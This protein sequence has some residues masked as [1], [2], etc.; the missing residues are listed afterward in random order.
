MKISE[1]E[2][3]I[4]YAFNDK[5]LLNKALTLASASENNNQLLE[6]FGDA[7]LEF[8]VSERIFGEGA[9]EGALTER[10]KSLVSDSA[11]TPVSKKLGLDKFLIRGKKDDGNKKAI[12]SA[13]EAV[14]A[15]IYLDGGMDAAKNFVLSTLDFTKK[16]RLINFK[17]KL[18]ELLQSKG[19]PVPDYKCID[20][21]TPQS[22]RFAVT[23]EV[24]GKTFDGE[25]DRRSEAEQLAAQSALKYYET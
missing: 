2:S 3:A 4:G 9:S 19:E 5:N 24:F 25:A 7:I 10:R 16:P 14:V 15:A 20:I 12:P 8:I 18:Q 22:H 6:F 23:V 11:L 21:G 13:Y 1:V 17:G